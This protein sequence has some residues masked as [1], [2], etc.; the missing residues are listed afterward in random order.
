MPAAAA[1][2]R[3]ARTGTRAK[4]PGA[5]RAGVRG[6]QRPAPTVS[7]LRAAQSVGLGAKAAGAIAALLAL[8]ILAAALAT[9]GRAGRLVHGTQYAGARVAQG[10]A[11][12]VQDIR[13]SAQ[14]QFADLGLR[15]DAVHLQGA[16]TLSQAAILRA[17]AIRPGAPILGLDLAA[18]R[19]RVERVGWVERAK[20]IRLLPDTLVIAV[21]ERRLLA[22][23][24]SGGRVT[25]VANDGAVVPGLDPGQFPELPRILGDG[26]NTEA[27]ALLPLIAK[28]P[29]LSARLDWL[30]RVDR[31]RWDLILKDGA[32]IALP[33]GDVEGAL[34]RLDRLDRI[35]RVLSLGVER[36]DLRDPAFTVVRPRGVAAPAGETHGA[37]VR[38]V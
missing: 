11:A 21:T 27:R 34:A 31:R 17:A 35:S 10:A 13:R 23:W 6:A 30:R 32:V 18:I 1:R 37:G 5:A 4:T 36:I 12:L 16:S 26:A 29:T 14:G 20:V 24:Q 33:E 3:R 7:K 2:E 28:H 8:L 22:V 9:G 19:A 38:G 15:V 25:V